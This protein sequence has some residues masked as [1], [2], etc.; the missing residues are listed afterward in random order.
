MIRVLS[1]LVCCAVTAGCGVE[2]VSD[3]HGDDCICSGSEV[4]TAAEVQAKVEARS[5]RD[6]ARIERA[7]ARERRAQL[8]SAPESVAAVDSAAIAPAR[9]RV[10]VSFDAAGVTPRSETSRKLDELVTALERRSGRGIER[11]SLPS[12]D[13]GFSV[14]LPLGELDNSQQQ[15]FVTDLRS[16]LIPL[17]HV[18]IDEHVLCG[19]TV[20]PAAR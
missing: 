6:N 8:Q 2:I 19:R 17:G 11:R 9:Y 20:R 15:V 12:N 1:V 10:V 5:E 13:G 14:C 4:P 16:S 7:Q 18:R 3:A